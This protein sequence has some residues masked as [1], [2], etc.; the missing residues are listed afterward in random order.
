MS[1]GGYGSDLSFAF[2]HTPR[3]VF[4]AGAVSE[5]GEQLGLLGCSKAL[6][7]TD[8][9][10]AEK[11]DMIARLEKALG[12]RLAGVFA[13]VVPDPT[14]PSVDEGADFA[15]GKGADALIS[16][17]GGSAIDTAKAMAVVLTEG[18]KLLDH[19]GYHN[20]KRRVTPHIAVPTTAGTG[21]EM[22]L[23]TV[24]TDPERGQKTY[25]GSYFLHPDVAVLDP[26]L[27]VGLPPKLTAA[28]GMD[29]MSHA[30]EA[31]ISSL[32]QPFSDAYA[33]RAIEITTEW[34][35]RSLSE[36]GDLTARGQMLMAASMAGTA[37]SNAMVSLNHAMA[38]SLGA[39]YHAH[40]GTLNAILLPYTMRFFNDVC[41]ERFAMVAR[42]MGVDT[43][44]MSESEAGFSAAD[45]M[46]DFIAQVGLNERLADHGVDEDGLAKVAEMAVSDGAIIYSP[47]PVFDTDEIAGLLRQAL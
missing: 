4:G 6:I 8:S 34:L 29:A 3:I 42:A 9:F 1:T 5:T 15:R 38:H 40:H 21:S 14:A 26:E 35:P 33:L 37:F 45:R 10:L 25:V 11:T 46:Q 28:T 36:P 24:I 19:E 2:A 41:A 31:L 44:G 16:L 20:L 7:V 13:G 39:I 18:G 27:V 47:K 17:G 43:S 12:P 30:V 32:R 23:V 22:T